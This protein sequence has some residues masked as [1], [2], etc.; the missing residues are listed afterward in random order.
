ME[1]GISISDDIVN[2]IKDFLRKCGIMHRIFF[3]G[4]SI[5]S[6]THKIDSNP[7]KYS[8]DGKKIQDG[9][10]VRVV[11]YFIE[12]VKTLKE[13][14]IK[15]CPLM[16]SFDSISDSE[17]EYKEK[18]NEL[19]NEGRV[20]PSYESVFQPQ[21]LNFILRMCSERADSFFQD[22]SS[23]LADH[24][25]YIPLIDSTYELQI[26]SVLSEGWHEVEHDLR[27]KCKNESFWEYCSDESRTLNGI[28]AAIETQ[29]YALERIFEKMAYMNYKQ[30]DWEPM[31]R[32]HFRLQLNP[33]AKLSINIE[34]IFN[35]DNK[36]AKFIITTPRKEL[37]KAL[38]SIKGAYPL[39]YDNIVFIA[40]RLQDNV[41]KEIC[42]IEPARIKEI[43]D[44][45]IS[46]R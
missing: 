28:Y 15:D 3:R 20:I 42:G 27:Y 18:Y 8:S 39:N 37:Q 16:D 6:L 11:L 13:F 38:L 2:D 5:D 4:K 36:T 33:Y 25:E 30:N 12:D 23:A 26:R 34:E 24:K 10:G 1:I 40:N 31:I 7:G 14:I 44:E 43:L 32:N 21:R 29:E 41:N 35:K 45:S 9:F 22:I 46:N 17:E 19:M